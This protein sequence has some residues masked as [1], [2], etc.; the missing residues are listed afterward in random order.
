MEA[1]TW[2]RRWLRPRCW[3][4]NDESRSASGA[5]CR[6]ALVRQPWLGS[7]QP[8]WRTPMACPNSGLPRGQ[9][10]CG[11]RPGGESA[12]SHRR[13]VAIA[14]AA[15]DAAEFGKAAHS[16]GAVIYAPTQAGR[17]VD[18]RSSARARCIVAGRRAWTLRAGEARART[19]CGPR[20]GHVRDPRWRPSVGRVTRTLETFQWLTAVAAWS[21][22]ARCDRA[23]P[24]EE[25]P[26]GDAGKG[27]VARTTPR[28]ERGGEPAAETQPPRPCP[29]PRTMRRFAADEQVPIG[30]LRL[31]GP[32]SWT[33][34]PGHRHRSRMTASSGAPVHGSSQDIRRPRR[35]PRIP[36]VFP[37]SGARRP[38]IAEEGPPTNSRNNRPDKGP[39]GGWRDFVRWGWKKRIHSVFKRSLS[40][41]CQGWTPVS[42][43]K[44][45]Q[46]QNH[47]FFA[48]RGRARYQGRAVRFRARGP[49]PAFGPRIAQW[50]EHVI[51]MTGSQRSRSVCAPARLPRDLRHTVDH[52]AGPLNG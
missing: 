4:A 7:R 48:N 21:T 8:D 18:G 49:R 24:L 47:P 14:R 23:S 22:R 26:A 43:K 15:L 25:R 32:R 41:T 16:E 33:P 50:V 30:R 17:D 1:V 9:G 3:P 28:S 6:C 45:G 42:V 5:A 20:D 12:G 40:R 13:R 19:G 36:A 39:A 29:T 38:G 10:W 2:R 51:R 37:S 27:V 11:S 34:A 31:G 46:T 52:A 44:R 35:G